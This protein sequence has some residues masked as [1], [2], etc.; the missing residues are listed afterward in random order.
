MIKALFTAG[1]LPKYCT[2]WFDSLVTAFRVRRCPEVKKTSYGGSKSLCDHRALVNGELWVV[3]AVLIGR[4]WFHLGAPRLGQGVS[5]PI[6]SHLCRSFENT[7]AFVLC[8][9]FVPLHVSRNMHRS[10]QQDVGY[11][12]A[13]TGMPS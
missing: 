12:G 11:A 9:D 7:I 2:M 13:N 8:R 10:C 6:K 3:L 4:I 1:A 5:S